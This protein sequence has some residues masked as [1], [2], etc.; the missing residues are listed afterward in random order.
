MRKVKD[1]KD[2]NGE[3]FYPK[4]HAKATYLS[5]GRTVE[6]AIAEALEKGRE[7]AKRDLYIAAGALY[8]DTDE[9][10]KRT[11][12]WGEE[13]DHLP[14]H[15]YL[16]GLG[17][18]TE[19]QMLEIYEGG[20]WWIPRKG[21]LLNGS[22]GRTNIIAPINSAYTFGYHNF[23][24]SFYS[25]KNAEVLTLGLYDSSDIKVNDGFYVFNDTNKLKRVY[26]RIVLDN[27]NLTIFGCKL[28]YITFVLKN[29]SI[30]FMYQFINKESILYAINNASATK[31][32]TITLHADAYNR[33]ANDVDVINALNE[34]NTALASGGG[35]INLVS[36]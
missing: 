24:N 9:V 20:R 14:K 28:E 3:K 10:I 34:K 1:L 26:G 35:S 36:A 19:E 8:N 31:A 17:D 30:T 32:I 15:Y 2:N 5:D 13:V 22:K 12:F 33:L 16:N 6:D 18:I 11:A 23:S 25:M 29:S 7:L 27:L 4:S 21:Y